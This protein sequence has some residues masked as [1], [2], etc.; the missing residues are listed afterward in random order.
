[1]TKVVIFTIKRVLESF[2]IRD[3]KDAE[4]W[5]KGAMEMRKGFK[6]PN[7]PDNTF[8]YVNKKGVLTSVQLTKL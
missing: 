7:T 6:T 5:F 8:H 3:D 4:L 2:V 1:M